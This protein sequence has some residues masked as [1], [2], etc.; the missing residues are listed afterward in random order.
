MPCLTKETAFSYTR[1]MERVELPELGDGCYC[2]ARELSGEERDSYTS[3]LYT[4]GK[5]GTVRTNLEHQTARLAVLGA[6]D[7]D[8]ERIFGDDEV[9][10]LSRKLGAGP[11]SRIADAVRRISGLDNE[12]AEA[13]EKK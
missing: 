12:S 3:T 4:M 7:D 9:I 8:G 10:G 5:G 2:F 1:K 13:A 6:V 11:L